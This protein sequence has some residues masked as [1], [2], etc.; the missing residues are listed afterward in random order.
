VT[1]TNQYNRRA[2]L[3]VGCTT[4]FLTACGLDTN[5]AESDILTNSAEIDF[6]K[7]MNS[8]LQESCSVFPITEYGAVSGGVF[9]NT[10]IIQA[11]IYD[12]AKSR[13]VVVIPS[14]VWGVGFDTVTSIKI[15]SGVSII[16]TGN[17]SVLKVLTQTLHRTHVFTN[18]DW[19]AGNKDITISSL[20]I[21]CSGFGTQDSGDHRINGI[22]FWRVSNGKAI[23]VSVVDG[24]GY[25]IWCFESERCLVEKC[26]IRNFNDG[27]E[28]SNSTIYCKCINNLVESTG[29]Y[30]WVSSG[31]LLY[32]GARYNLISGNS[33]I[34]G[35]GQGISTS[36]GYGA[37]EN[38]IIS[39][40]IIDTNNAPGILIDGVGNSIIGN[41]IKTFQ[42]PG[43]LFE[44]RWGH[45]VK[46][47]QVCNNR[48]ECDNKQAVFGRDFAIAMQ[49][50]SH[51]VVI[52]NNIILA[53][54]TLAIRLSGQNVIVTNN[55]INM[56]DSSYQIAM[57][58]INASN[59][60]IS[61]NIIEAY[62]GIIDES[63]SN[64][65]NISN[66]ISVA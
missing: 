48:F 53:D 37:G 5:H 21:D 64:G 9:D 27:I 22:T 19:E 50:N 26:Y 54:S 3:K 32:A 58:I 66:N 11:A 25:G 47:T 10:A 6:R 65:I 40:N 20:H 30:H 1:T 8:Y 23:D 13:G 43:L 56:V 16:G 57:H 60:V 15:P 2:L 38:N 52:S 55:Q 24:F 17:G 7:S 18:S 39:N 31:I 45:P 62:D 63:E 59:V 34:G 28:F 42:Q 49:E 35:F 12:A 4:S 36:S 29:E 61:H 33:V 44:S 51:D 41:N 46:G 14:G